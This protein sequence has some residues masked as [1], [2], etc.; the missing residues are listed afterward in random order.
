[1]R[2]KNVCRYLQTWVFKKIKFGAIFESSFL[3][4]NIINSPALIIY[5]PLQFRSGLFLIPLLLQ[6]R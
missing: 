3:F 1:M 6:H 2:K 5:A 4:R